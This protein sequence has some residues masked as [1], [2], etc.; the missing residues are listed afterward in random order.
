MSDWIDIKKCGLKIDPPSLVLIYYDRKT[1]KQ[2]RRTMPLRNFTKMSYVDRFAADLRSCPRNSKYVKNLPQAQLLR[3]LTIIKD[4]LKGMSLE[5][6]LARNLEMDNIDPE[7]DLNKVDEETLKRKK[8]QMDNEFE[9]NRKKPGDP[10]FQYDVEVD[11]DTGGVETSGW[12]S[13]GTDPEF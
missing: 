7:Q 8:L 6:S 5:A 9:K 10:D 3:M 11:F 13:E 1:K 2:R 12:D 4:R